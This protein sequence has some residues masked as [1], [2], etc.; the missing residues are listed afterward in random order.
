MFVSPSECPHFLYS[1]THQGESKRPKGDNFRVSSVLTHSSL[2]IQI[3]ARLSG[4][5]LATLADGRGYWSTQHRQRSPDPGSTRPDRR[6]ASIMHLPRPDKDDGSLHARW[7][8]EGDGTFL[9]GSSIIFAK[10]RRWF[11][12]NETALLKHHRW[13]LP[14]RFIWR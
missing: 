12:T 8:T 2:V 6:R 5:L 4:T 1:I 10:R 7:I 9:N 13:L 11:R 3:S 14:M